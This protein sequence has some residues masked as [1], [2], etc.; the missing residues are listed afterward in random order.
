MAQLCAV[1]PVCESMEWSYS[2]APASLDVAPSSKAPKIITNTQRGKKETKDFSLVGVCARLRLGEALVFELSLD[3]Q[4]KPPSWTS[5][6]LL[7]V[8]FT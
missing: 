5:V 4:R 6:S 7:L 2:P 8:I 1:V 3:S